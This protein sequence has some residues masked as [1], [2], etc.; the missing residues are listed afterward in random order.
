MLPDAA[1]ACSD[2]ITCWLLQNGVLHEDVRAQAEASHS[3]QLQVVQLQH[4]VQLLG[5]N[6]QGRLSLAQGSVV[7][8]LQAELASSSEAL[9]ACEGQV[10]CTADTA[11]ELPAASIQT[12]ML[13]PA[14]A[15]HCDISCTGLEFPQHQ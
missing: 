7:A 12:F 5:G 11:T 14:G 3:L 4:N 1:I 13:Y 2:D 8:D 10:R 6:L 15:V 9:A